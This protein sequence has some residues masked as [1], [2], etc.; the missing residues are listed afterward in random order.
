MYD[1]KST[2]RIFEIDDLHDTLVKTFEFRHLASQY[3]FLS[4]QLDP[5]PSK[6]PR[7][8]HDLMHRSVTDPSCNLLGDIKSLI[9]STGALGGGISMEIHKEQVYV[10]ELEIVPMGGGVLVLVAILSNGRVYVYQNV[11]GV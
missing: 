1:L 9:S 11:K 5:S 10:R 3:P 7:S 8:S 6:P 2:L 4:N